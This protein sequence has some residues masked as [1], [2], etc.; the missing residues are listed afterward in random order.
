MTET[1]FLVSGFDVG[2]ERLRFIAFR[3]LGGAADIDDVVQEAW[4]QVRPG[5]AEIYNVSEWLTTVAPRDSIDTTVFSAKFS[6][7]S[8]RIA[9]ME[10]FGL[11]K[12]GWAARGRVIGVSIA[13]SKRERGR[14]WI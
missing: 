9:S 13:T 12:S 8:P 3:M 1:E 7:F 5:G 10:V 4:L 2:R 6:P 11:G 14:C